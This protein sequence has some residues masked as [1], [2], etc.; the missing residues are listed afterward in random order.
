MVCLQVENARSYID[1]KSPKTYPHLY[2]RLKKYVMEEQRIAS[3]QK[4]NYLL[5]TRMAEIMQ[6]KG[7][8]DNYNDYE[9]KR[10]IS[11][12]NSGASYTN[13]LSTR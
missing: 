12:N 9:I 10:L 4:D 5:L 8:L 1:N 7:S 3:I 13:K 2:Q 11:N 6:T